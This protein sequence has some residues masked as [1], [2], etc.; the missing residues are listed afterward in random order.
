MKYVWNKE[1]GKILNDGWQVESWESTDIMF[2]IIDGKRWSYREM[3]L[4]YS[5]IIKDYY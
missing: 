5:L 1:K 3:M 2:D 4:N